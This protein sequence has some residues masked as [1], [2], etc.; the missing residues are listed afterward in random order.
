MPEYTGKDL[1]IAWVHSGG[2]LNL[3]GNY[4]SVADTPSVDLVDISAGADTDRTYLTTLRDGQI[5]LTYLHDGGSVDVSALREGV[6][7][8]IV[9]GPE[10]TAAGKPK[11]TIPAISLGAALNIVYNNVVEVSVTWQRNG[12]VVYGAF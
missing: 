1:Y 6:S 4:R 11:R 9:Y 3:S 5:A 8:T 7:G 12:T 2:T 10:G